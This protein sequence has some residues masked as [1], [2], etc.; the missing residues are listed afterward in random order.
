MAIDEALAFTN[1]DGSFFLTADA[2]GSTVTVTDAP[3]NAVT[4]YSYDPFGAVSAT[5]P[6]FP[7][8][9]QFTGG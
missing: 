3:G 1:P 6:A 2:L 7:N 8:S 5:N 4:E 9:F